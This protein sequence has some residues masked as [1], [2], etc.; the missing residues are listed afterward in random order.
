MGR[1]K[2]E[3]VDFSGDE[4]EENRD[5]SKA[6]S[7]IRE[8]TANDKDNDDSNDLSSKVRFIDTQRGRK[9]LVLDGFIYYLSSSVK[10]SSY[11]KCAMQ[12]SKKCTATVTLKNYNVEMGTFTEVVKGIKPHNNHL[13]STDFIQKREE[14]SKVIH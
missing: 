4:D 8:E 1:P 11:F 10:Q 7:F 12:K 5:T 3:P 9:A 13:P 14:L 6:R 2:K